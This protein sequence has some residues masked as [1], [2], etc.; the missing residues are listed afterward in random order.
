MS[1]SA[2]TERILRAVHHP[3]CRILGHPTGRLLLAR[4]GYELD[5]DRVLEACAE[6]GVSV[7]INASPYRLDLDWMWAR[8]AIELGITLVINPDA[9]A[10]D[11]LDDVR[12][13]VGVAR[14]AGATADDILNCR[15][16]SEWIEQR[17]VEK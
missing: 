2:Q 10:V 5:L 16:L 9:H 13:G 12:W 1:E 6:G 3:A 8:R 7:E 15:D 4:P 11:G 14:K 17:R